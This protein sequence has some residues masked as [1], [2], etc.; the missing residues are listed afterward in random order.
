[1]KY[2]GLNK[3]SD[4]VENIHLLDDPTDDVHQD[5][6]DAS[7]GTSTSPVSFRSFYEK[8]KVYGLIAFTI[9]F[10]LMLIGMP[11]FRN[12]L[13]IVVYWFLVVLAYEFWPIFLLLVA[14]LV[15]LI[16]YAFLSC[17]FHF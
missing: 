5:S 15:I 11:D 17:V 12:A 1:M 6:I 16:A 10:V 3:T 9:I 2:E 13:P 14:G 8:S 4:S 7:S